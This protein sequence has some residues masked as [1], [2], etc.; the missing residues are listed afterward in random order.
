MN[1]SKVAAP[2]EFQVPLVAVYPKT[3]VSGMYGTSAD[4]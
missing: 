1:S 4:H 2:Q 3:G